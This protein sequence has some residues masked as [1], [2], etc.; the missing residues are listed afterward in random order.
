MAMLTGLPPT[1]VAKERMAGKGAPACS[2]NKSS[3]TLPT[4]NKSR[5]RAA[6]LIGV[7]QLAQV[8]EV[9]SC[10]GDGHGTRIG[11]DVLFHRRPTREI[12][13]GQ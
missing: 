9:A 8:S 6:P 2:E 3:E 7:T 10:A 11:E 5:G 12:Q 1:L 4:V 13:L